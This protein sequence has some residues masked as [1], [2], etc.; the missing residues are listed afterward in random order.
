MALK[1][2]STTGQHP[3]PLSVSPPICPV[4]VPTSPCLVFLTMPPATLSPALCVSPLLLVL[5]TP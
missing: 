3:F 2:F 1:Y 4:L 5:C